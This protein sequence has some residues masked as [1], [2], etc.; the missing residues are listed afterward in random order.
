MIKKSEIT[1]NKKDEKYIYHFS[2]SNIDDVKEAL[3]ELLKKQNKIEDRGE[4]KSND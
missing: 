1:D 2:F 4:Y 3:I